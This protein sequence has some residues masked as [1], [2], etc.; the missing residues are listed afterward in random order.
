MEAIL[1]DRAC[2]LVQEMTDGRL[3]VEA[4]DDGVYLIHTATRD[5]VQ[6]LPYQM[7]TAGI[8]QAV[9]EFWDPIKQ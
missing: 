2:T 3:S 4:R 7:T 6:L 5:R 8:K 9:A 1:P